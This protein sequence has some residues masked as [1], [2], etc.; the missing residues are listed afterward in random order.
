MGTEQDRTTRASQNQRTSETGVTQMIGSVNIAEN[1]DEANAGD[2]FS[3]DNEND[4][5]IT[6]YI[7]RRESNKSRRNQNRDV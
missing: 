1:D 7:N 6:D 2:E 5:R 3:S 4:P